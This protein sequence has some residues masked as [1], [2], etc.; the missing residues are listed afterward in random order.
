MKI[1]IGLNMRTDLQWFESD[2]D[3]IMR[4]CGEFIQDPE[5]KKLKLV[6][7]DLKLDTGEVVGS[8][9]IDNSE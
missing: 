7:T 4:E 5:N 9:L 8:I 1:S 6:S 3:R 2:V